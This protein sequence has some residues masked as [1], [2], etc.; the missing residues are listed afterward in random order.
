MTRKYIRNVT[1]VKKVGDTLTIMSDGAG[2]LDEKTVIAEGTDTPR[3]L[4]DWCADVV[5]IKDTVHHYDS[6]ITKHGA[7]VPSGTIIGKM[8]GI[9]Q[10]QLNDA[11][12]M[13]S[14]SCR[15]ADGAVLSHVVALGDG[16]MSEDA[17]GVN[18]MGLGTFALHNIGPDGHRNTAIGSLALVNAKT[19]KRTVAL[20]RDT[21]QNVINGDD[22]L[23]LGYAAAVGDAP[24]ALDGGI[25]NFNPSTLNGVTVVGSRSACE[26]SKENDASYIGGAQC[27]QN[28]RQVSKS[29]AIAPYSMNRVGYNVSANWRDIISASDAASYTARGNDITI[30]ATGHHAVSGCYVKV[31]FT[32]GVCRDASPEYQI[33]Y[34]VSVSG[35]TFTVQSPAQ[36]NGSGSCNVTEYEQNTNANYKNFFQNTILG[37]YNLN[38]AIDVSRSTIIGFGCG[39]DNTASDEIVS[40]STVLG[41]GCALKATE[42]TYANLFGANVA[43]LA[44]IC[45]WSTLFGGNAGASSV[46]RQCGESGRGGAC[47]NPLGGRVLVRH[48]CPQ[49]RHVFER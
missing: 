30:T 44:D 16:V 20:G 48:G 29:I 32:S 17:P 36:F 4:K 9:S 47:A 26:L 1:Q 25:A 43:I 7:I 22:N 49:K 35:N 42:L 14:G 6:G 3:Q 15:H 8:D 13:G 38:R 19:T 18:N 31:T 39:G 23:F 24:V 40:Y 46:G 2:V 27:M 12:V 37:A 28:A 5:D 10:N 21:G 33:L 41:S 45:K 11:I 34:V